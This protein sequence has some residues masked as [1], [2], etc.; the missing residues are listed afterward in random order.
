M[1]P[2][3]KLCPSKNC[4]KAL[5]LPGANIIKRFTIAIYYHSM[6]LLSI[7]ILKQYSCSNNHRMAINYHGKKFYNIGP[8]WQT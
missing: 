5:T 1:L 2:S 8:W 7:C 6:V 4:T 3:Q